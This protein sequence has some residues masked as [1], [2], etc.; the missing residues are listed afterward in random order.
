M[1]I[2]DYDL[3][4]HID[5]STGSN[6]Y[7]HDKVY[8]YLGTCRMKDISTGKWYDACMYR[9]WDVKIDNTVGDTF[10]REKESFENEFKVYE[11]KI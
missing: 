1:E 3:I 2:S 9:E 6:G 10:V 7:P 8:L 5:K 4:E 11:A